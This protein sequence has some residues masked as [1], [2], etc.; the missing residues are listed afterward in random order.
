MSER[1]EIISSS[2][3]SFYNDL[4]QAQEF[5][6]WAQATQYFFSIPRS[7]VLYAIKTRNILYEIRKT[8]A[9]VTVMIIH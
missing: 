3:E 2:S 8:A 4:R 6:V 5:W 1:S 7:E 9:G